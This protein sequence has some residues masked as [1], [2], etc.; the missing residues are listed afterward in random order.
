L[1]FGIGTQTNNIW[2]FDVI[3]D[4]Y[5]GGTSTPSLTFYPCGGTQRNF[6][7]FFASQNPQINMAYFLTDTSKTNISNTISAAISFDVYYK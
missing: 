1:A 3:A 5:I 7:D 4:T 2:P 6:K